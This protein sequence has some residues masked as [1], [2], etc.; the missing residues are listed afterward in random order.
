MRYRYFNIDIFL[1]K[2]N[3]APLGINCKQ[4]F[5]KNMQNNLEKTAKSGSSMKS[6]KNETAERRGV[7]SPMPTVEAIAAEAKN[8]MKAGAVIITAA[9]F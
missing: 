7:Q 9:E 3:I 4:G 5:S 8:V 2:P 6:V 1:S